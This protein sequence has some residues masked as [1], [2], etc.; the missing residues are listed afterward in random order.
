MWGGMRWTEHKWDSLA[1]QEINDVAVSL[2]YYGLQQ[3]IGVWHGEDRW[4]RDS[5][6]VTLLHSIYNAWVTYLWSGHKSNDWVQ[7]VFK[8]DLSPE[9]KQCVRA[10]RPRESC[11]SHICWKLNANPS[12][13]A[14]LCLFF[15]CPLR[16]CSLSR[17]PNTRAASHYGKSQLD[18][19][20]A[21]V[22]PS[23]TVVFR[24]S[25]R[26]LFSLLFYSPISKSILEQPKHKLSIKVHG[27]AIWR[28]AVESRNE[29]SSL[30][31]ILRKEI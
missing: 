23:P 5:P 9:S 2:L 8:E 19:P 31:C 16:L 27:G 10:S 26:L 13:K 22:S 21:L 17:H 6:T 1:F 7:S 25:N 14:T 3:W 12:L 20:P 11:R 28:C 24:A 29:A 15:Y 30:N 4:E 18:F